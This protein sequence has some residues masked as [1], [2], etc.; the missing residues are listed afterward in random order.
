MKY[1]ITETQYNTIVEGNKRIDA[2]QELINNELNRIKDMCDDDDGTNDYDICDEVSSIEQIVVNDVETFSA[3][4]TS[5]IT[6]KV[7][8]MYDFF[9]YKDYDEVIYELKRSIEKST[10]LPIKLEYESHNLKSDF[11]W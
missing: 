6:I 3:Y 1:I 4:K 9:K 7:D 5:S 8:V 11:Q 2:F 10:G